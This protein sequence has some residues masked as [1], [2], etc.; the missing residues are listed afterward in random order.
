[1]CTVFR[2]VVVKKMASLRML[3]A[4]ESDGEFCGSEDSFSFGGETAFVDCV[5]EEHLIENCDLY[6]C[7]PKFGDGN[8]DIPIPKENRD[9]CGVEKSVVDEDSAGSSVVDGD[10][11]IPKKR[12]NKRD[13]EHSVELYG[14]AGSVPMP[15]EIGCD[16]ESVGSP[17]AAGDNHFPEI[18]EKSDIYENSPGL[19]G[20]VGDSPMP[21]EIEEKSG[22]GEK[23]VRRKM[24]KE[25][26]EDSAKKRRLQHG[27]VGENCGCS[28]NCAELLS[29]DDRE[30]INEAY[31]KLDI[32]EQRMFIQQYVSVS[33]VKQRRETHHAAKNLKKNRSYICTLP[34]ANNVA[35]KVCRTFFF[36]HNRFRQTLW[37]SY[38]SLCIVVP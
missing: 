17:G 32:P 16:E 12:A 27:V 6:G 2:F 29:H 10:I 5:L 34:D 21:D 37:V 20:E 31:W 19:S 28:K 18:A 13:L 11:L 15:E 3:Q 38:S 9:G 14:S 1:M 36:E 8:G 35:T 24:K 33:N 22:L 25:I 23:S 4:Y 26:K 30:N 7:L